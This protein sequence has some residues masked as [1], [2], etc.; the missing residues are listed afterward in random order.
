MPETGMDVLPISEPDIDRRK[1]LLGFSASDATLLA[2]CQGW[3][4]Q[5]IEAIVADFHERLNATDE[6]AQ[7]LG[8]SEQQSRFR[9]LQ[10]AY[11]LSLFDGDYGIAYGHSRV[12]LGL[13][14]Q[15]HGVEPRLLLSALKSLKET[16]NRALE[17]HLLEEVRLC[18]VLEALDKLLYFDATLFL[19]TCVRG[20]VSQVESA[21]GKAQ[22]YAQE[23][24][25]K[26]AERTLQLHELSLR[27][28]LTGLFNLSA[29]H[30]SLRRELV[31]AKRQKK[32]F[33]LVYLDI[34]GFR[35]INALK[36]HCAGD[37]VLQG[38]GDAIRQA[39][40]EIDI[41]CRSG[42]DEFCLA[43]PDCSLENAHAVCARIL[44]CLT[45]AH[46]HITLSIGIVQTGPT[47]FF[48]ADELL[49]LA[50]GKMEQA[51]AQNG[52]QICA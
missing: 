51:K 10:R 26:V 40:R 34:D 15:Q 12:R 46:A 9:V 6:I 20:L 23:L 49:R 31:V 11:V 21:R 38:V 8:A 30:H 47:D 37:E 17:Q 48:G 41:P 16:L 36:G 7:L 14:Y 29:L 52:W 32:P 2:S 33:S 3:V 5:R 50:G 24:E 13:S 4:S 39:C 18:Q 35:Q 27:D 44:S 1:N 42:G 22:R 28:S 19:D 25:E 45:R 43:L